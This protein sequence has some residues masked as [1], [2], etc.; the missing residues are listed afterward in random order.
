MAGVE[1]L[2]RWRHPQRG[3]VSPADFIPLAE[4]TGLILPIGRW[5]LAEACRQNRAWQDQGLPKM[6][7]A[8]NISAIQLR[9]DDLVETVAQ[10]LREASLAPEYLE[11]E[12]TESVVMENAAEAIGKLE[13]LNAMGVRLSIDDFGTGYSSLSYLKSLPVHT[14]KVDRAFIQDLAENSDAALL[15]GAIVAM[16][17]GLKRT[18]IAEGVETELQLRALRS[19]NADQYQGFYFSKPL[20]AGEFASLLAS[21]GE[22]APFPVAAP[23]LARA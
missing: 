4:E 3:L 23:A 19:L 7:V 21:V 13:R 8:V 9:Q 20:P 17:H 2:L 15:V 1:A 11:L 14:L 18:V 16:A 12:I 10:A 22:G 5:V 6:R